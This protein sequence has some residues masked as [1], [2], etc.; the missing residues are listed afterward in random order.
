MMIKPCSEPYVHLIRTFV[1][2]SYKCQILLFSSLHIR[3][4]SLVTVHMSMKETL[5]HSFSDNSSFIHIAN[6]ITEFDRI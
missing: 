3:P 4:E 5:E 1:L 2:D 6:P